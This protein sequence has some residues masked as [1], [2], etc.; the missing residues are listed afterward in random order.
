MQY[1][2]L[3]NKKQFLELTVERQE[4]L[5]LLYT[6]VKPGDLIKMR[7]TREV[8]QGEKGRSSSRR[9][10]MT[11]TIKVKHAEF[12][13][14]TNRLRIR[15]QIVEGPDRF[16]LLGSHHTLNVELGSKLVVFKE[17]GWKKF[18]LKR[19]E[20]SREWGTSIYIIAIDYD[21]VGAGIFNVQGLRLLFTEALNISGK[22]DSEREV[23]LTRILKEIGKK[24]V[25][26]IKKMSPDSIIVGGPGFLKDE[27]IKILLELGVD[28][29]KIIKE[30]SSMGGETGVHEIIRRGLP[31][32]VLRESELKKAEQIVSEALLK[33]VKEPDLVA[34]GLENVKKASNYGAIETILVIDELLS[35]YDETLRKEVELVLEETENKRGKIY[36]VPVNTPT[37][38]QVKAMGGI[39]ALLRF[40]VASESP[41]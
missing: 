27:L 25:N 8:K 21:E 34:V 11:L 40:S 32:Q 31:I 36:I 18:E 19:L 37:G 33:M 9:I 12:Q 13:P 16:G 29:T 20:K 41:K 10:P 4:D 26:D 14:F 24:V 17:K 6:L 5:W 15:G 23:K 28:K 3:D 22:D 1:T 35:T 38:E 39:I 2:F 30:T 7:T